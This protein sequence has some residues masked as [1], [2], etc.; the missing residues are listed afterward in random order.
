MKKNAFRYLMTYLTVII[1]A[2]LNFAYTPQV[3]AQE[4]VKYVLVTET[5]VSWNASDKYIIVCPDAKTILKSS[6]IGKQTYG[7]KESVTINTDGNIYPSD[8]SSVS[9]FAGTYEVT[10]GSDVSILASSGKYFSHSGS[11]NTLN[12]STTAIAN[13]ISITSDG[14]ATITCNSR[15][16]KYNSSSPRF[17]YYSSAQTPI[18][19]YKRTPYT[20]QTVSGISVSPTDATIFQGETVQLTATLTPTGATGTIT[21]SS[22]APAIAPVDA[23]GLVT[24]QAVG[25]ATITATCGTFTAQATITVEADPQHFTIVF[26]DNGSGSDNTKE[27]ST[28][29]ASD[30]IATGAEYV[31]SVSNSSKVYLGKQ[32]YG[33]KLGSGSAVGKFTLNLVNAPIKVNKVVINACHYSGDNTSKLVFDG[34]NYTLTDNIAPIE[35]SYAT[36]KDFTTITIAS[37]AKRIY[38]KSIKIYPVPADKYTVKLDAAGGTFDYGTETGVSTTTVE[39]GTGESMTLPT[40]T[41]P[42]YDFVNWSDGTNTY[43]GGATLSAGTLGATLELTATWTAQG[44]TANFGALNGKAT[45][46]HNGTAI[47]DLTTQVTIPAGETITVVM[48]PV[49]GKFYIL[50][51]PGTDVTYTGNNTFTFPMPGTALTVTAPKEY[52]VTDFYALKYQ[53]AAGVLTTSG[54]IDLT[55]KTLVVLDG[56]KLCLQDNSAGLVVEL[57]TAASDVMLRKT[58]TAGTVEGTFAKVGDYVHLTGGKLTT[59]LAG[60]D[61]DPTPVTTIVPLYTEGSFVQVSG[62]INSWKVGTYPLFATTGFGM[63]QLT[64]PESTD[65]FDVT[66]VLYNYNGTLEVLVSSAADIHTAVPA[67]APTLTSN[68]NPVN[69]ITITPANKCHAFYAV[70]AKDA[71]QPTADAYTEITEATPVSITA[72]ADVWTYGV[73]DFYTNSTPVKT[74]YQYKTAESYT[75]TVSELG[76]TRAVACKENENILDKVDEPTNTP[77]GLTFEYYVNG[78]DLT[79]AAKIGATDKPSGAMT[80]YAVYSYE[81]AIQKETAFIPAEAD[82][83]EDGLTGL[84]VYDNKCFDGSKTTDIGTANH[85]DN[86]QFDA[87]VI[88]PSQNST[89]DLLNRTVTF[90]TC[91]NGYAVKT[92]SGVYFNHTG[93]GAGLESSQTPCEASVQITS[94]NLSLKIGTFS[95]RYNNQGAGF[96]RFYGSGQQDVSFYSQ[97]E[98]PATVRTL[99]GDVHTLSYTDTKLSVSIDKDVVP[100]GSL[101]QANVLVDVEVTPESGMQVDK[102]TVNGTDVAFDEKNDCYS[103]P[104][105]AADA[106]IAVTYKSGTPTAVEDVDAPG[107]ATV[108]KKVFI[109]GKVYI[110]RDGVYYDMNGVRIN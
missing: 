26:K 90:E 43:A 23:T 55:G 89:L 103:F 91:G 52:A 41:R 5:P 95:L 87:D 1:T 54:S 18:A 98:V 73:R 53:A 22:S 21:Y 96:F 79:T 65:N 71:A 68:A 34:T 59:A 97:V 57:G 64:V 62:T 75:I 76:V 38:V 46:S 6:T 24:G 44:I 108:V 101:V 81:D 3:K 37:V 33:L 32:G 51:I 11:G 78:S 4:V 40:P 109:D 45:V 82:D 31:S 16:L 15:N 56:K 10:I 66:G 93:T 88:Y 110:V 47:A 102:L 74:A 39:L 80:I 83:L 60:T 25:T 17:A 28:T 99:A 2:V 94:G 106:T 50:D 61:V 14:D 7:E 92:K 9:D 72:D 29:D 42:G 70:V 100:S 35:V 8:N 63:K 49:T 67:G 104:M 12:S 77:F 107:A 86:I 69:Q 13:T 105:P 85:V 30:Y 20:A 48:T 58:L 84:I 19:L 36:P 27:I